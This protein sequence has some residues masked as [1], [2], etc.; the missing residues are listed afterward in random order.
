MACVPGI[1]GMHQ[2][3]MRS[4]GGGLQEPLYSRGL[5]DVAR[6]WEKRGSEVCAYQERVL[7]ADFWD[8][9]KVN[10]PLL[11]CGLWPEHSLPLLCN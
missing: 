5:T 8:V 3:G 1:Q 2:G 4:S 6:G 9:L 10:G 11:P 7:G